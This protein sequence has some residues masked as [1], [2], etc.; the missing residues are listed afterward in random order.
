MKVLLDVCTPVQV[1]QA[2]PGHGVHTAV[3]M[4]WSEPD[5][6]DLLREAE[7]AKFDLLIIRD[8]NLRPSAESYRETA[9]YS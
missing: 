9:G 4:G 2:L 6:G 1:R 8:K 3:K 7:A 5:N